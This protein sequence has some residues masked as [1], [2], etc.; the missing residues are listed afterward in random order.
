MHPQVHSHHFVN[1][2]GLPLGGVTY[3][4]GFTASW[5]HGPT[6]EQGSDEPVKNG[7]FVEDLLAA[8]VDRLEF[9]QDSMFN[10]AE[11]DVAIAYVK[12]ALAELSARTAKRTAR[13]VEGTHKL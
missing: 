6:R 5:Q 9:Y 12:N 2:E 3:G 11:N 13:G 7:C 4:I 1:P 8:V 10:C